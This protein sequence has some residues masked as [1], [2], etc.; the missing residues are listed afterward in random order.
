M[1]KEKE[2]AALKRQLEHQRFQANMEFLQID[3]ADG[4]CI[5]YDSKNSTFRI[6]CPGKVSING[7]EVSVN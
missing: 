7:K 3:F 6:F 5:N 4:G 1:D 2:T